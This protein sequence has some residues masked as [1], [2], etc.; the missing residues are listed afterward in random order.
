MDPSARFQKQS[1]DQYTQIRGKLHGG[2]FTL[3][4]TVSGEDADKYGINQGK[5][6]LGEG[7][8]GKVKYALA[9]DG[10]LVVVK[11]IKGEEK[12]QDSLREIEMMMALKG[13]K[14]VAQCLDYCL[15][16]GVV[17]EDE[18]KTRVPTLYI[19]QPVYNP[20]DGLA[21]D[22]REATGQDQLNQMKQVAVE[23]IKATL[24]MHNAGIYHRD[25]KP[26]NCMVDSDGAL[27]LADLGLA[28]TSQE[29]VTDLSYAVGSVSYIPPDPQDEGHGF[30]PAQQDAWALG[31]TLYELFTGESVGGAYD[32]KYDPYWPSGFP[33]TVE[34]ILTPMFASDPA[35]RPSLQDVMNSFEHL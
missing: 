14:G 30:T 10:T 1:S 25:I 23:L 16:E 28:T 34:G 3:L 18:G 26:E 17:T 13:T 5:T 27:L 31:V 19:F 6:V 12:I 24:A 20:I 32:F 35:Q 22:L 7:G 2:L 21:S 8:F 11:S 15:T 9:P 29:P 33:E 4:T